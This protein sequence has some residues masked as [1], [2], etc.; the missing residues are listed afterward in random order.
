[1]QKFSLSGC[2][3]G[4]VA[5]PILGFWVYGFLPVD[6]ARPWFAAASG[7]LLAMGVS[8]LF[9]LLTGQVETRE[10]AERRAAGTRQFA[11]GDTVLVTGRARGAGPLLVA[12]ISGTRCLAYFYRMYRIVVV[13]DG[14]DQERPVY[15]GYASRPLTVETPSRSIPVSAPQLAIPRLARTGDAA[16]SR[17]REYVRA[18]AWEPRGPLP[19]FAG[20]PV[21]QWMTDIAPDEDGGARRD[22]KSDENLDRATWDPW[23]LRLEEL[24]L[25]PGNDVTVNGR[26]SAGRNA[27]VGD[28]GVS[29]VMPRLA[30]ADE[31][32]LAGGA[33]PSL[34]ASW[35]GTLATFALG[36][37]LIWF[38]VNVWPDLR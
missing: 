5:W 21:L 34:L 17:A 9:L 27:V 10:K 11:D 12:P 19:F 20:D 35:I 28:G 29:G 32:G 14:P 2:A 7:M 31:L 25:T 16:V 30:P 36:A 8:S 33:P 22:W 38:A 26:W 24:V 23:V 18:A 15:W 4:L 13:R 1:M 3:L 6:D 37:G